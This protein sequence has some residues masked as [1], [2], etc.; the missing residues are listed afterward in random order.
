MED[1][2]KLYDIQ[3]IQLD[4][5]RFRNAHW[6][7]SEQELSIASNSGVNLNR[8]QELT[9]ATFVKPGDWNTLLKKYDEKD[10]DVLKWVECRE[11]IVFNFAH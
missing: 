4:Y 1:A 2:F 3:G 11:D 7:F 5:I 9:Y 10:P 8:I 6:G